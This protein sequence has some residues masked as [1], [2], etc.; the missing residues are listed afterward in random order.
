[1]ELPGET[2]K[3]KARVAEGDERSRLYRAQADLN[4]ADDV[5]AFA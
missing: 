4:N 2:F 1:M 5:F 3:A